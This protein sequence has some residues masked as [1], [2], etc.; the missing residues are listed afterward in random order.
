M[1]AWAEDTFG[2]DT[3]CDWIGIFLETPELNIVRETI[4]AVLV[5]GDDLDSDEA[6]DCLAACE[7]LAR[8]QGK[9]GLKNAY[10]EELDAW[11]EANPMVVPNDL[12]IAADLAIERILGPDSELSELW[13]EDG[14]NDTWHNAINDLRERVRG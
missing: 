7:V 6:C 1:G 13:D 12:K 11:V 14:R 9:W 2:N 5:A 8:L 4:N 3:S 10:S